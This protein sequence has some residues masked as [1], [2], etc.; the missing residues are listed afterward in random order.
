MS[1]NPDGTY[2]VWAFDGDNMD[3]FVTVENGYRALKIVEEYNEF[4]EISPFILLTGFAVAHTALPEARLP[5]YCTDTAETPPVCDIFREFCDCAACLVL[6]R[7][8]ACEPCP[9]L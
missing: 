1:K 4:K 2:D 9:D 7:E 5:I 6:E 8:G 3:Q